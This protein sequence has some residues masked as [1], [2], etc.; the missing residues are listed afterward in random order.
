MDNITHAL[1]G[2]ALAEAALQARSA[3]EGRAPGE[4]FSRLAYLVSCLANNLPDADVLY[5]GLTGGKLGSLL[6]HRGHTHTAPVGLLL[7]AALV[8]LASALARRRGALGPGD[9]AWLW[10]LGLAGPLVH[11]SMDGWNVYGVHPFWPLYDGWLYGDS[12]FIVEPLLWATLAPP[13]LFAARALWWRIALG[14]VLAATFLLPW[15][16]PALVPLPSRLAVGLVAASALAFARHAGPRARAASALA[17]S[18]AV[19]AG[20]F[21]VGRLARAELARRLAEPGAALHDLA[22]SPLP[23]DPLC[24]T[25]ASVQTTAAGEYVLRRATFAPFASI[26]AADRCPVQADRITAPLAPVAAPPDPSV[27]WEGEFRAPLARLRSLARE[28]CDAAA[29][30][31]FVRTPFWAETPEGTV[32]GDLRFDRNDRL[33]FAEM[34]L[35]PPGAP[36][37]RLVPTWRPPRSDLLDAPAP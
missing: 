1:A 16:L 14:I 20:F 18:V 5:T 25:V 22:L 35:A 15:A 29:M 31:R 37:P 10:G 19:V 33:G 36:C 32:L 13:L 2:A 23:A 8:A 26:F 7:G 4:P 3:R 24:W 6:H 11:M 17:A 27:R 12:I 21:A 34:L 30:L 28:R 9:A